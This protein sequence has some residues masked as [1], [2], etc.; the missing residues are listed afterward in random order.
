MMEQIFGCVVGT[1]IALVILVT[2]CL[3][4]S[5]RNAERLGLMAVRSA[6]RADEFRGRLK[7]L[8]TVARERSIDLSDAKKAIARFEKLLDGLRK[9]EDCG[10]LFEPQPS[11][12]WYDPRFMYLM[13]APSLP[14][15]CP[16]CQKAADA[17]AARAKWAEDNAEDVDKMI[18][19]DEVEAKSEQEALNSEREE[20]RKRCPCMEQGT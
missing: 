17:K 1:V 9:C 18:H 16:A 2:L 11:V 8:R 4:R 19:D 12:D 10:G 15:R 3:I 5:L 6:N 14:T 13:T 7:A 20:A